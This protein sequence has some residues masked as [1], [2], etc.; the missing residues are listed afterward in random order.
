M[1]DLEIRPDLLNTATGKLAQ[2]LT[3]KVD[4]ATPVA[5]SPFVGIII[6]L[7]PILADLLGQ[8]CEPTP[9]QVVDRLQSKRPLIRRL[10]IAQINNWTAKTEGRDV[11]LALGGR[12]FGEHVVDTLGDPANEDLVKAAMQ[13]GELVSP[14]VWGIFRD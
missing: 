6:G 2:K 10:N 5:Q 13:E 8:Y 7:L 11:Y 12:S 4:P 14:P 1:S 3:E 9:E